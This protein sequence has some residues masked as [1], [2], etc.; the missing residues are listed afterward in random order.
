MIEL[1]QFCDQLS[2]GLIL[3]DII[4]EIKR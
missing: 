1:I 3:I 2:Y 4:K